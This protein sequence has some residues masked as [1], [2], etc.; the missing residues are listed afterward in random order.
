MLPTLNE[1]N[2]SRH[3]PLQLFCGP[4][5]LSP[6]RINATSCFEYPNMHSE[7]ARQRVFN[8]TRPLSACTSALFW[9]Q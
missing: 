9:T 3:S 8:T 6:S 7:A 4:S 5:G 2:S 1:L